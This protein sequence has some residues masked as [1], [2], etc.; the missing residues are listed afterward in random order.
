MEEHVAVRGSTGR[1]ERK[2]T[3][4]GERGNAKKWS[5]VYQMRKKGERGGTGEKHGGRG[6]KL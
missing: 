6:G 3:G 4:G 2:G 1:R 5:G